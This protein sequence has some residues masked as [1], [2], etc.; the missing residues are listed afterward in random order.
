MISK[1][2]GVHPQ[3][4]LTMEKFSA[5]LLVASGS[6]AVPIKSNI[7]YI[8]LCVVCVVLIIIMYTLISLINQLGI[9]LTLCTSSY[10]A[11]IL[12]HVCMQQNKVRREKR[13]TFLN[14]FDDG[15][16]GSG[17]SG[18]FEPVTPVIQVW[19]FSRFVTPAA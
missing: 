9:N 14:F 15:S 2:S 3:S 16:G 8:H 13:S 19:P 11:C 5:T 12:L 17:G 18:G 4:T 10:I 6:Q 7:F 1:F